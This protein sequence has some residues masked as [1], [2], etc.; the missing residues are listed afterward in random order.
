LIFRGT[1]GRTSAVGF[2]QKFRIFAAQPPK[3]ARASLDTAA[4]NLHFLVVVF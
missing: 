2:P 4:R 1:S 3:I